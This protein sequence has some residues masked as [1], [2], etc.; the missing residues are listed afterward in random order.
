MAASSVLLANSV[1]Q[2]GKMI[3]VLICN[4]TGLWLALHVKNKDDATETVVQNISASQT[5]SICFCY[6]C[7]TAPF[8]CAV[9]EYTRY[10][11]SNH[12]T[13]F[14]QRYYRIS[15]HLTNCRFGCSYETILYQTIEVITCKIFSLFL[16][17]QRL[18][19]HCI[20]MR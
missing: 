14:G 7:K 19:G 16:F 15:G 12:G 2:M 3:K 11:W 4:V 6:Q 13:Y 10:I 18:H 8:W 17:W 20:C 1:Q 5:D 9:V